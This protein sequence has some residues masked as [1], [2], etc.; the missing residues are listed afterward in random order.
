MYGYEDP[1]T[2][3]VDSSWIDS[4]FVY[5]GRLWYG[6][7]GG[8]GFTSNDSLGYWGL[9]IVEEDTAWTTELLYPYPAA[10]GTTWTSESDSMTFTVA[11]TGLTV[12]VPAGTFKGCIRYNVQQSEGITNYI[13]ARPGIGFIKSFYDNPVMYPPISVTF[14]LMSFRVVE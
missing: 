7:R 14:E 9:S 8:S 2:D 3:S 1:Y 11:A 10:I 6:V 5:Q 13:I 4:A 12:T